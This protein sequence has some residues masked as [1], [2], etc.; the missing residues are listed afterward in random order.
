MT[1]SHETNGHLAV[2]EAKRK[3]VLRGVEGLGVVWACVRDCS[4]SLQTPVLLQAH[5]PPRLCGLLAEHSL[6]C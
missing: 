4:P 6:V 5:C 3:G 1:G 2:T